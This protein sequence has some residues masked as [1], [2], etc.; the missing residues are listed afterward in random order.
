MMPKAGALPTAPHLDE[1]FYPVA[2]NVPTT[3]LFYAKCVVL[4][5]ANPRSYYFRDEKF[6]ATNGGVGVY[7]K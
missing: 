7:W 5:T 1:C 3:V 6:L 4:S 2:G